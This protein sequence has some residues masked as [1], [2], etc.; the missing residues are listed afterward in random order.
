MQRELTQEE[1]RLPK[2]TQK[3]DEAKVSVYRG[4][5]KSTRQKKKKNYKRVP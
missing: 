5:L 3:V 4:T 2:F 1:N